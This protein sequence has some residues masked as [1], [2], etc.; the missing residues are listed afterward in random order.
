MFS[1]DWSAS[2]HLQQNIEPQHAYGTQPADRTQIQ[3]LDVA[4]YKL[5]DYWLAEAEEALNAGRCCPNA[6]PLLHRQLL[7]DMVLFC[8]QKNGDLAME[9][10]VKILHK[11]PQFA[12][13]PVGLA[14][15]GIIFSL[16]KEH[17]RAIQVLEKVPR[18]HPIWNDQ[19]AS[20]L[21]ESYSLLGEHT[22][23][24]SVIAAVCNSYED[25]NEQH[26]QRALLAAKENPESFDLNDHGWTCLR[27]KNLQLWAGILMQ[28][29][30]NAKAVSVMHK[31][32]KEGIRIMGHQDAITAGAKNILGLALIRAGRIEEAIQPLEEG[33]SFL[34]SR[35][36]QGD[37]SLCTSVNLLR[38]YCEKLERYEDAHT[39]AKRHRKLIIQLKGKT[40]NEY[41]TSTVNVARHLMQ[42]GKY[43]RAIGELSSVEHSPAVVAQVS[44]M[45]RLCTEKL[46]KRL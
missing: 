25:M 2:G 9:A 34:L 45:V 37:K 26:V 3:W 18:D 7:L 22:K 12:T 32:V 23:A 16:N 6:N 44:T 38:V 41:A 42:M 40:S 33:T 29:E 13:D 1:P 24:E 19:A 31:A 36:T 8:K 20:W 21:A 17:V 4:Q 43:E 10:C 11:Y 35:L 27:I 5:K 28:L 46:Q 30:R 39:H 14:N 15:L